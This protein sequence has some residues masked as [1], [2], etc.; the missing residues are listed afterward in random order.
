MAYQVK[1]GSLI[2]VARN[3]TEVL[4]LVE[5]LQAGCDDPVFV[6]DMDGVA[7]D[8]ERFRSATAPSGD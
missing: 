8:L 2:I 4:K 6:R 1:A 7:I 3:P 5:A